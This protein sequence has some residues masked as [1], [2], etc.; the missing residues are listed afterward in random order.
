MILI[1]KKAVSFLSI[2]VIH[3][4]LFA[5]SATVVIWNHDIPNY[6]ISVERREFM[7]IITERLVMLQI[8]TRNLCGVTC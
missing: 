1:S 2:L 5:L 6:L 7:E 4:I 8:N 3:L